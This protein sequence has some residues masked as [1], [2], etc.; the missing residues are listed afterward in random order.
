[1]EQII[2][3]LREHHQQYLDE[4]FALTRFPS[5]S[6]E[7]KYA[8]D[9]LDC[10]RFVAEH[11]ETI[12]LNEVEVMPTKRHPVV[13]AEWLEAKDAPTV[14]IYGHYDV[15]PAEP[16]E[17]WDS[18][19]FE[20]EIR[21]GEMY[22]R[23]ISDDKGQFFTYV[24]AIEAYLKTEGTLPVNVKLLIEGEE[25]IGS[26]N[27]HDFVREH[28]D[29]LQADTILLSDGSMFA[30]GVPSIGYGTRGL[31]HCQIDVE[32]AAR[33]L[34]SGGYGGIVPN[35]IQALANILAALKDEHGRITIPGYYNDVAE[36]TEQ[37]KTTI[38]RFGDQR[39]RIKTRTWR[40]GIGWRRR[41]FNDR[42]PMGA[43]DIGL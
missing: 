38:C 26:E 14:L 30:P 34:H 17:L 11:L 21:D 23:G 31:I 9:V 6:T 32:S 18:P 4:L 37:E 1:M 29:L 12:G 16:L 15:Q 33:D 43:P 27:L 7:P 28:A 24:K 8:G 36:L 39:R 2:T 40:S 13:Y 41:F 35:P 22:A 20:P 25:E 10:A 19:P 3:H 42:T 5:V